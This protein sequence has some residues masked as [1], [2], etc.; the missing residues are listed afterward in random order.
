MSSALASSAGGPAHE[1]T[2]GG[3][4][5]QDLVLLGG[6]AEIRFSVGSCQLRDRSA[7]VGLAEASRRAASFKRICA[8]MADKGD[9]D[10]LFGSQVGSYRGGF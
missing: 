7:D 9:L 4:Q 2:S 5:P 1:A 8:K 6:E 3:P 10:I